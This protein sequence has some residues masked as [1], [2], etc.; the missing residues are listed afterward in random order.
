MVL[1]ETKL[2]KW[3]IA[4]LGVVLLSNLLLYQPVVQRF[5]SIEL[6]RGV[7]IGSLL[8]FQKC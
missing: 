2:A 7:V 6:E 4:L 5:L 1:R 8:D 3:A